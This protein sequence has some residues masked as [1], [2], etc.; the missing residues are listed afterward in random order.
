MEASK[1]DRFDLILEKKTRYKKA[2]ERIGSASYIQEGMIYNIDNKKVVKMNLKRVDLKVDGNVGSIAT[3]R[4]DSVCPYSER[5]CT[6]PLYD[7][8]LRIFFKKLKKMK[9]IYK[10]YQLKLWFMKKIL[11]RRV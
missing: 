9:R 6:E 10:L 11:R 7:F 3:Y 5:H 1:K 2:N 4:S 8:E